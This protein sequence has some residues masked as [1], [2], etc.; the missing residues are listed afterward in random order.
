MMT[1]SYDPVMPMDPAAR[2]PEPYHPRN[3]AS[4]YT[5]DDYW[6]KTDPLTMLRV[7]D[8]MRT[9]LRVYDDECVLAARAA[10]ATWAEI[11]K[12]TGMERQNA[13]RKWGHL[14]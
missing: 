4:S 12:A 3:Y 10:G 11:G 6:R 14:G 5:S 2:A 8:D 1:T 9:A 13:Q 7:N